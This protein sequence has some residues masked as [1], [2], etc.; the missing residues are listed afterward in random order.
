VWLP[1]A[2][3]SHLREACNGLRTLYN[4]GSGLGKAKGTAVGELLRS[5]NVSTHSIAVLTRSGAVAETTDAWL[6][7]QDLRVRVMA[8]GAMRDSDEFN[9]IVVTSWPNS[10]NMG[11]LVGSY[12]APHIYFV[13]YDFE[14]AWFLA[15]KRNRSRRFRTEPLRAAEKAKLT[16]LSEALFA[17]AAAATGDET[18]KTVDDEVTSRSAFRIEDILL[19]HR[20]GE[21][22]VTATREERRPAKYV[23][24]IGAGYALLTQWH[25]VPVIT[26]LIHDP[27]AASQ[28]R[29]PL[30]T[31][32]H[33]VRGDV[34]LFREG[35][36]SNIIRALAIAAVGA[37]QYSR[38]REV[39]DLW[40]PSLL[41]LAENANVGLISPQDIHAVLR[42][43][44]LTVTVQALRGWLFDE[45]RIGPGEE[46]S[47][48][49]IAR[50]ARDEVLEARR[51][52]VWNAIQTIRVWHR[53]AG[54]SLA[55]M[56]LDEL[57]RSPPPVGER[58]AR[59]TLGQG[60]AWIVEVEEI[61]DDFEETPVSQIN[62]LRWDERFV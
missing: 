60:H 26:G 61:G 32:D 40:R 9:I 1:S 4:P 49:A 10:R 27:G 42:R 52:E 22:R 44:G 43:W 14:Q 19:R 55:M 13:G 8:I 18:E 53:E 62:H 11:Q 25:H 23:G 45:S 3:S 39:A 54:A 34:L 58:E 5:L 50:A 36:E 56:L 31:I 48:A 2:V 51:T 15:F 7:K 46:A 59:V 12:A 6:G 35:G 57:R 41:R 30:R 38:V 24:F 21:N 20:K 28:S 29:V 17:D 16:G 33:I 47:L 37:G